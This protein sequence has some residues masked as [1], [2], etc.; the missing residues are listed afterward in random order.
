[1]A[2]AS[3]SS[4]YFAYQVQTDATTLPSPFTPTE[5]RILEGGDVNS[6]QSSLISSELTSDRQIKSATNGVP[7]PSWNPS[8]EYSFGSFDDL[9]A[10]A[11][12]NN[13]SGDGY[14]SGVTV[15]VASGATLTTD[16]GELWSSYGFED[17]S[18][19]TITGLTVSSEDGA[20]LIA[21]GSGSD[22]I[23]LTDLSGTPAVFT[24]EVDA[25]LTVVGGRSS[26]VIDSSANNITVDATGRTITAA[27]TIWTASAPDIRY[28]DLIYITGF[29]N[30]GNNGWHKVASVSGTVLTVTDDSTLV[31]ESLTTGNLE[32]ANNTSIITTGSTKKHFAIESGYNDVSQYRYMTGAQ[33]SSMDISLSTDSIV[34]GSFNFMGRYLSPFSVS[35]VST[36]VG[37]T[38]TSSVFNTF[39]GFISFDGG[40]P[41]CVTDFSVSIDNGSESLMCIFQDELD[42]IV[43]GKSNCSGSFSA[44]FDDP[45]LAN[46]YTNET[47]LNIFITME[48][49]VGNSISIGIPVAKL[50]GD[51]IDISESTVTESLDFQALGTDATFTNIY[52]INSR[53]IPE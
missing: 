29:S 36:S 39:R 50:Q 37:A 48:D 46:A 17:N 49:A 10:G 7:N 21:S 42:D 19:I 27:S 5:L 47:P 45:T 15:D 51:S 12:Q 4:H 35:P 34:T 38:T 11:L 9:I 18:V 13:W 28:N 44:Y 53:A 43:H 16:G 30:A 32:V 2:S 41:S 52:F 6:E 3:G 26:I 25:T 22:T 40:T 33:V 24:L 23:T 1:M 14:G 8:V 20:Y 31:N